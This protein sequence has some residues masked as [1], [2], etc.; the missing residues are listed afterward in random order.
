MAFYPETSLVRAPHRDTPEMKLLIV[1]DNADMR[2]LITGLVGDLAETICECSDGATALAAYIEHRPDWVLM[3]IK[4]PGMDGMAATEQ[5]TGAF[6]EAQIVMVTDFGD[7]K[8]RAQANAAGACAFVIKEDLFAL[9]GILA[10][11]L[12]AKTHS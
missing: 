1:D 9:R 4:M 8:L 6:P 5:I 12:Q 2:R 11:K 3:D 10:K 7:A